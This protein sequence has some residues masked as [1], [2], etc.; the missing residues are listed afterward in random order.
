MSDTDFNLGWGDEDEPEETADTLTAVD[1]GRDQ[2]Q[3]QARE[4]L[5]ADHVAA[6]VEAVRPGLDR[7]P[8]PVE[9]AGEGELTG[10]ELERLEL[11]NQGIALHRTAWFMAGKALDT[12]ATGKLF[13]CTPHKLEPGRFYA[14]IE[15]WAEVE[16]GISVS[17]CSQWR[18]AWPIGEVLQARGH[19]ANPGQV[20]ELVPVKN[21]YGLNAA[22]AVYVLVAESF[23]ADKVTAARVRETVKL[24]PGNLQLEDDEDPDVL[25]KTIKGVLL[26]ELPAS[27]PSIPP[28]VTR[29]VD[30]RAVDLANVL[31]R[32]RIARSEV[33]LYLMQAFADE[34][35]PTVYN[36]VLERMKQDAK[37]PKR[38]P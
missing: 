6:A 22:V 36:A 24:M 30:R 5:V 26:G 19:D 13:R 4:K 8:D 25:A 11:C 18:A 20:R 7:I 23:G 31:D 34:D 15:E 38:R 3:Q 29:A 35:D 27:A 28:A 33:N 32:G 17:K 12:V 9:P 37:K 16:N 10:E 2:K 21:G 14:T 1:T